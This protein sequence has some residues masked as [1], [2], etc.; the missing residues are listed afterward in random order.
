[1]M[2]RAYTLAGLVLTPLIHHWLHRRAARGKEDRARMGERFGHASIARP[3]GQLVWLHAASVGEAQSVLTLVRAML[4]AQPER[5]VLVTTGT[6]TSAALMAQHAVPRVIH[7]FIPVDTSCAAKRF[8][9]HW[10]PDLALWVESEFWPQLLLQTHAARI[11]LL[12]INARL[13][14]RSFAR[15]QRW[16]RSIRRVLHC[17]DTVF[18]GSGDDATRLRALSATNV[19]EAGNLKFDA[20]PLTVDA[21]ALATLTAQCGD[22]PIWLA[23]S[24]HGNEEFMI[25]RAHQQLQ[26]QFP[27]LLTLLV[28]RHAVRGDSIASE[29]RS[30]GLTLAQRSRNEPIT[31]ATQLYLADTMG[32]LGTFYAL[33]PIVFLGGSLIAHGGHNPLEPA[34]QQCAILSG[35]YVHNFA[36]ISEQLVA[37]DG[38]RIVPDLDGLVSQ[39]AQLL[40]HPDEARTL[41]QRAL[42]HTANAR[43]ACSAILARIDTLLQGAG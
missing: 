12:L 37:A 29:L 36:S 16:P 25:A 42:Q 10:K 13:S 32:E 30:S 5:T 11:P 34:R 15:W 39:V 35:P 38:M 20:A 33:A 9:R 26:Q 8:L 22:R 27:T 21:A 1:M 2:L 19:Q 28:P 7:Q 18:A 14:A 31:A 40:H 3:T 41:A 43:G 6:V 23:A 17:F 24:T 4:E